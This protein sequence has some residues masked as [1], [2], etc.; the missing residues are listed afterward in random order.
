MVCLE[1]QRHGLKASHYNQF[2]YVGKKNYSSFDLPNGKY[3][4]FAKIE[5]FRLDILLN[6]CQYFRMQ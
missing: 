1:E 5:Y 2:S 6:G 3:T 4:I